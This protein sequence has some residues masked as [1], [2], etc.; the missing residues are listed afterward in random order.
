MQASSYRL[1]TAIHGNRT[2]SITPAPPA[3]DTKKKCSS[4]N[5]ILSPKQHLCASNKKQLISSMT[6]KLA[7]HF[8][9]SCIIFYDL[10]ITHDGRKRKQSVTCLTSNQTMLQSWE[11]LFG[12]ALTVFNSQIHPYKWWMNAILG[13]GSWTPKEKV[14]LH[15]I[16]HLVSSLHWQTRPARQTPKICSLSQ[17]VLSQ[18]WRRLAEQCPRLVI[19]GILTGESRNKFWNPTAT[20]T[21]S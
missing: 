11:N 10:S 8:S 7:R 21:F 13:T 4:I 1:I 6:Q 16:S 18:Q 19:C 14:M 20:R 15:H 9:P 5:M 2:L 12:A 3:T 17:C